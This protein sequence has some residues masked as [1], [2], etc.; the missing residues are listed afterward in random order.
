MSIDRLYG[1]VVLSELTGGSFSKAV[2]IEM[3]CASHILF[4]NAM[5]RLLCGKVYT[6]REKRRIFRRR[7]KEW[8]ARW[9]VVY[10]K[11]LQHR[12][13]TALKKA[14]LTPISN[15]FV[16]RLKEAHQWDGAAYTFPIK[17]ID[18]KKET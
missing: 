3:K 7:P 8:I 4:K 10:E 5:S 18:D 1:A 17:V 13:N 6:A 11:L 12:G 2:R 16:G 9:K 14:M 15:T